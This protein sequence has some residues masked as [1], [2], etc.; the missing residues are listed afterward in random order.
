MAEA[1]QRVLR[2]T[3]EVLEE[4]LMIP[5]IV[6]LVEYLVRD[7]VGFPIYQRLPERFDEDDFPI[8]QNPINGFSGRETLPLISDPDEIVPGSFAVSI[9]E[10]MLVYNSQ[11]TPVHGL[12]DSYR[13]SFPPLHYYIDK[14]FQ[15]VVRE[16]EKS[17]Y[18]I[19]ASLSRF[20]FL[21]AVFDG[22]TFVLGE[23]LT[24]DQILDPKS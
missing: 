14:N 9:G 21:A 3:S 7:R 18:S 16:F 23:E 12:R 13:W 24:A 5:G 1:E 6:W 19:R 20:Q 15:G 8:R 22:G 17:G 4:E 11:G 10:R 2:V